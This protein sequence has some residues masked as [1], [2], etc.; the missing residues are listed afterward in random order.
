MF[1]ELSDNDLIHKKLAVR[2]F[3]YKLLILMAEFYDFNICTTIFLIKYIDLMLF[4][5]FTYLLCNQVNSYFNFQ[6]DASKRFSNPKCFNE[7]IEIVILN[8]NKFF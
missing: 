4:D 6:K 3:I 8:Q 2:G 1:K 5:I 7:V